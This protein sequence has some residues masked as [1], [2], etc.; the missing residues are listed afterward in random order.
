LPK[1]EGNA[2]NDPTA[3]RFTL[4]L[5]KEFS[6]IQDHVSFKRTVLND[7]ANAAG[8]PEEQLEIVNMEASRQ[9]AVVYCS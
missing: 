3:V 2:R 6:L 1:W 8:V 7:I 5:Q 4:H 9:G